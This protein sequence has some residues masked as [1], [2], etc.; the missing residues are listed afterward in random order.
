M[1]ARPPL[2]E[3]HDAPADPQQ[4]PLA[5]KEASGDHAPT[6]VVEA[7]FRRKQ[8]RL[9]RVEYGRLSAIC[10]I[11]VAVR[12]RQPVFADSSVATVAVTVLREH[13]TRTG[14]TVHAYCVMPDHVHLLLSPSARADLVRFVAEFKGLVQREA[15]KRGVEGAFWQ[16]GFWDHFLR[17]DENLLAAIQYVLN[18]PVRAGLATSASTYP[19]SGVDERYR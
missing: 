12:G 14:V 18:N 17:T 4:P 3:P 19:F 13:G 2:P 7:S 9:G 10:S 6:R 11:T 1:A 5:L 15:W 16:R 8:H